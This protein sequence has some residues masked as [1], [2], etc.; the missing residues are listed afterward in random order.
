MNWIELKYIS[1]ILF[2]RFVVSSAVNGNIALKF[3]HRLAYVVARPYDWFGYVLRHR[4]SFQTVVQFWTV[5][6]H[7]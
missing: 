5:S 1:S 7:Y 6:G 2:C 4:L 3:D